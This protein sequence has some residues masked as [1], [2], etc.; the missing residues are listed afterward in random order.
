MYKAKP[1]KPLDVGKQVEL[2]KMRKKK[3]AMLA[4]CNILLP[5]G[6]WCVVERNVLNKSGDRPPK[7]ER[8]GEALFGFQTKRRQGKGR[9]ARKRTSKGRKTPLLTERGLCD[10]RIPD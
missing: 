10:S 8:E 4:E 5:E 6:N 1:Q 9:H 2:L 3:N 7:K